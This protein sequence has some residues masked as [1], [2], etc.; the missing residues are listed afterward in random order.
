MMKQQRLISQG[1][2]S[3]TLQA[4]RE[5][6]N[7]QDYQQYFE[8]IERASRLDPANHRI[9]LDLG[10]AYGMR[11]D[12]AAAERCFEKAVRVAPQRSE[13]LAMAGTHCRNFNQYEMARRFFERAAEEPGAAPDT[14]AKLAELYERLRLLDE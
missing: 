4:A 7:R 12:Y 13:A 10:L 14:L 5:S 11:Y 1:A 8:M 6:W 9:L 3:R 2:L